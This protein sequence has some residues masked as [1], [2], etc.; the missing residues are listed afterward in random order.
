MN[1]QKFPQGWD[2]DRV[3]R[4]LAET[5]TLSEEEQVAADEAAAAT[6]DG[7]TV[8]SVPDEVLP[9]I[10]QLLAEHKIV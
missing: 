8:I 2:A 6:G 5:A 4:L 1:E 10:R 3:K 7:H 9:A